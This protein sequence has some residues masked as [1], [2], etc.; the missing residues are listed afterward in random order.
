MTLKPENDPMGHAIA[1][2]YRYGSAAK[3]RVLSPDMDEDEIPVSHLFRS[4][5][6]MPPLERR[7]ID[8]A[9]GRILDVGAGA[10]CH[11]LALQERGCEVTAIDISPLSVATMRLRGVKSPIESDFF[12]M[13]GSYDT[14]LMLMNGVGIVGT[15]ERMPLFFAALDRLLA[16]GG[17]LLCD[18]SDLS[19][20]FEDDD[21]II[22]YPDDVAYY[23]EMRFQM[24]Y[25]DIV[26]EPFD[27]LYIDSD[28][29]SDVAARFGYGVEV[30][31]RG[32]HFD[33]L[34]RITKSDYLS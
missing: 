28:T 31:A 12:E 2:Y 1:E 33:Y 6:A 26:G 7:A 13:Q 4:Y 30:T 8:L 11:A 14:I 22:C 5:T 20:L 3:L 9:H 16:P 21:G 18:S 34:A 24:A 23:G 19:Y 32:K 15:M 27:W 17:Q 25:R 29:L 10:G